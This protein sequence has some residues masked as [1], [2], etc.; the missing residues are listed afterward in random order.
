MAE[1]QTVVGRGK[2]RILPA[3]ILSGSAS[4][5]YF[6]GGLRQ[7]ATLTFR[8]WSLG[9]GS[10]FPIVLGGHGNNHPRVDSV[11]RGHKLARSATRRCL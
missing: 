5:M 7:G 6:S 9:V 8:P 10:T 11:C 3:S 2:V 1:T 4:D